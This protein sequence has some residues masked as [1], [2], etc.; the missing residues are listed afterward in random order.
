[1]G[2]GVWDWLPD[3]GEVRRDQADDAESDGSQS[4]DVGAKKREG[5]A[6]WHGQLLHGQYS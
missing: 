3:G 1:M 5:L 6:I 2:D 4:G